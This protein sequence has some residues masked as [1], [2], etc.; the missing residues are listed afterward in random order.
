[1]IPIVNHTEQTA[2]EYK[3]IW[4]DLKAKLKERGYI[5][6]NEE[7]LSIYTCADDVIRKSGYA[8]CQYSGKLKPDLEDLT[9][10]Q[11]AMLCDGGYS[12]FGGNCSKSGCNFNVKVYT[13]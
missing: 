6:D 5:T 2:I 10:L 8:E 4:D 3:N 12:W 1:M 7:I 13:D 9:A 11:V